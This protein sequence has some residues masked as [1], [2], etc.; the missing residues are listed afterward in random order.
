MAEKHLR[1]FKALT[2]LEAH[3]TMRETGVRDV[4]PREAEVEKDILEGRVK[5]QH[6]PEVLNSGEGVEVRISDLQLI[7]GRP[8]VAALR[9][10]IQL[11]GE[12]QKGL[13]GT[14]LEALN[15]FTGLDLAVPDFMQWEEVVAQLACTA[16]EV[17][18]LAFT[19]AAVPIVRLTLAPIETEVERGR[20]KERLN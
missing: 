11:I 5:V 20:K 14:G 1:V 7:D 15:R 17:G 10:G 12:I 16:I 6:L 13:L 18:A 9:D 8:R 19:E 3:L 4:V 2:D